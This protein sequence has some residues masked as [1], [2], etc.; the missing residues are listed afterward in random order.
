MN[1]RA[2]DRHFASYVNQLSEMTWWADPPFTLTPAEAALGVLVTVFGS[3]D[4]RDHAGA[5]PVQRPATF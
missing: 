1:S 2:Y 3:L 4:P 5:R